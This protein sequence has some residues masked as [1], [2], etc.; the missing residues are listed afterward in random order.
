MQRAMRV[1]LKILTSLSSV[2]EG[3]E[4]YTLSLYT[5]FTG[6]GSYPELLV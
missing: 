3:Y 1:S 2:Y 6:K 4:V 5:L